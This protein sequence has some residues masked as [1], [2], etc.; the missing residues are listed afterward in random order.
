M[1]NRRNIPTPAFRLVINNNNG[2]NNQVVP[3][4]N[5]FYNDFNGNIL[6]MRRGQ[7]P[8]RVTVP[9]RWNNY[10]T[11]NG[12]ELFNNN[13]GFLESINI[14]QGEPDTPTREQMR[15]NFKKLAPKYSN[16]PV[17]RHIPTEKLYNSID[18]EFKGVR[19]YVKPVYIN[20][21]IPRDGLIQI[22]YEYDELLNA[23][24]GALKDPATGLEIDFED[25]KRPLRR[26][27]RIM[28]RKFNK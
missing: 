5:G 19:N 12:N 2:N 20:K 8:L 14:N 10:I 24:A 17:G 6:R 26:S 1:N 16:L 9:S 27:E 4:L 22:A 21:D 15:K 11:N 28:K 23:I 3:T 7:E 13:D 18:L 25:I